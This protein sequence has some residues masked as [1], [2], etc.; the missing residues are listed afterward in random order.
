MPDQVS[1]AVLS[2]PKVTEDVLCVESTPPS[3]TPGIVNESTTGRTLAAK[4]WAETKNGLDNLTFQVLHF[5]GEIYIQ[6]I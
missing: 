6:N 4:A 2:L 3:V 1:P 5:L